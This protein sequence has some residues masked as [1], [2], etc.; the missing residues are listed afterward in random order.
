[1]SVGISYVRA[2]VMFPYTVQT[3]LYISNF[4]MFHKVLEDFNHAFIWYAVAMLLLFSQGKYTV[5]L[6]L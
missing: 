4:D 3:N 6:L 1:M 5:L 2:L